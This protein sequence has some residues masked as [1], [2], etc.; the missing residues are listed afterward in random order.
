MLIFF[1]I[2]CL[3]GFSLLVAAIALTIFVPQ[4]LSMDLMFLPLVA[5]CVLAGYI[6]QTSF[7][8]QADYTK[9][10]LLKLIKAVQVNKEIT[11]LTEENLIF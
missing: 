10:E 7:N 4:S 3:I 9:K 1:Y 8:H 5:L 6:A 2:E 11:P